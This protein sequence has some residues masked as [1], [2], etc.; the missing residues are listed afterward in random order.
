MAKNQ[1]SKPVDLRELASEYKELALRSKALDDL[2]KPL[3]SQIIDAINDQH[4]E[5]NVDLGAILVV[6]SSRVTQKMDDRAITPDWLYR[7]QEAGGRFSAK[8]DTAHA[9]IAELGSLL[10]EIDY[11]EKETPTYTFKLQAE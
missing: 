10:D 3:K 11:E 6:R 5:G 9:D 4:L 1:T 7:Y 2:M 8:L